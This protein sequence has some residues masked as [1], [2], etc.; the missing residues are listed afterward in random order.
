MIYNNFLMFT[1]HVNQRYVES[2]QIEGSVLDAVYCRQKK[3]K[4]DF[5]VKMFSHFHYNGDPLFFQA[6]SW[7]LDT[8]RIEIL[9]LLYLNY[10]R[11]YFIVTL[12]IPLIWIFPVISSVCTYVR[13]IIIFLYYSSY[14]CMAN[15]FLLL[16]N[17]LH[18]K[19]SL[20][21]SLLSCFWNSR[22]I[23]L[24]FNKT[25]WLHRISVKLCTRSGPVS[26]AVFNRFVAFHFM[27]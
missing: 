20:I 25:E 4:T 9:S 19:L 8:M 2:A 13:A 17:L 21:R 12:S 10:S 23:Y 3:D 22:H 5:C 16:S 6:K 7:F 26:A 11:H 15:T 1:S 27:I 14:S 24:R 18:F